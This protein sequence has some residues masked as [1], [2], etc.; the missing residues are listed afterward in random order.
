MD[1]EEWCPPTHRDP[2]NWDF[3]VNGEFNPIMFCRWAT[4]SKSNGGWRCADENGSDH[5][6][7]P[8]WTI[9]PMF[10]DY[11][12]EHLYN[13]YFSPDGLCDKH[14]QLILDAWNKPPVTYPE[15]EALHELQAEVFKHA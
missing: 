8:V 9:K 4:K 10:A 3:G 12:G 11:K 6:L 14:F 13:G 7:N 5:A 15:I 1:I 2:A